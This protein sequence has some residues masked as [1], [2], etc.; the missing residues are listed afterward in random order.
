MCRNHP[1]RSGARERE[2]VAGAPYR[3]QRSSSRLALTPWKT[4]SVQ[5]LKLQSAVC[6]QGGHS[7]M[8]APVD[9]WRGR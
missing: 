8:S 3:T 2:D 7:S 4:S 1:L 9:M 6:D 5:R